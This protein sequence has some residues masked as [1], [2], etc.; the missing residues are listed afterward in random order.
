MGS[1]N[2]YYVKSDAML[3]MFMSCHQWVKTGVCLELPESNQLNE[4]RALPSW[5]SRFSKAVV[6]DSSD[7]KTRLLILTSSHQL[8][9]LKPR[10]TLANVVFVVLIT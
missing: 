4:F 6:N 8:F 7:L 10:L 5:L 3:E 1:H 2:V 9:P